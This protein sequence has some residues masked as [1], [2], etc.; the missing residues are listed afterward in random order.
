[1]GRV[2]QGTVLKMHLSF[3]YP[4]DPTLTLEDLDFS[5]DFYT[6]GG[7]PQHFEPDDLIRVLNESTGLFDYYAPVDTAWLGCGTV[8]MKMTVDIPDG[9]FPDGK[10]R[11]VGVIATS[12]ALDKA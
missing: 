6:R 4:A 7:T 2:I 1:M 12:V 11:E 5:V 9:D 10:R 3:S 8:F